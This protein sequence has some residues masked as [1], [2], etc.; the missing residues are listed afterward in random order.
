MDSKQIVLLVSAITV[1]ANLVFA[2]S[3]I[4]STVTCTVSSA[5]QEVYAAWTEQTDQTNL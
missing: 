1:I 4:T 5:V 2:Y 3:G